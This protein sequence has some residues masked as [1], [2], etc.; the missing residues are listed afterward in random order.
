M[1]PHILTN[2]SLTVLLDSRSIAIPRT[3]ANFEE[4]LTHLND[5]DP[6]ELRALL[7]VKQSISNFTSG[8]IAINDRV[9]TYDGQEIN[10]SLSQKI[11]EFMR[12]GNPLLAD[13][14]IKFLDKLMLNPS[15]RA[16]QGLYDWVG[17]SNMPIAEDG[18]I[19]AWKCVGDDYF[20]YH[21]HTLD[22][23]PGNTV[24][25]PRNQCDE[26]PDQTCSYGIHFCSFA[27]L[28]Q[29]L[30]RSDVRVLLVKINPAN[31]VAIPRDYNLAKGRCCEM[32]VV[33]EVP[34]DELEGVFP[35]TTVWWAD[36]SEIQNDFVIGQIWGD[37][38][39]D[40]QLI[41][42]IDDEYIYTRQLNCKMNWR[43]DLEGVYPHGGLQ[44][45]DLIATPVSYPLTEDCVG[46]TYR[47]R[48]GKDREVTRF[49]E[50]YFD[51]VWFNNKDA[52]YA[53]NGQ[54]FRDQ[55][56]GY[57]EPRDYDIVAEVI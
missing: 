57:S 23:T 16:V 52:V 36:V 37:D 6:T 13:P 49:V 15:R 26:D 55:S 32:T 5:N 56:G 35:T 22:H 33:R 42:N 34:K 47:C 29:Y 4:I 17:A 51:T 9:L 8:R 45:D 50:G 43:F 39:G 28:P 25:L 7:D 27:Y 12:E 14:L 31:V 19:Y 1:I 11:M 20:D 41:I 53:E 2:Q 38:D 48:D 44:L 24:S 40:E 3:H 54:A 21:S 30:N 18:D 10:T 46:K